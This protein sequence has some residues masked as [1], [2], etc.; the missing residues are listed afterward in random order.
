MIAKVSRRA[1][2]TTALCWLPVAAVVAA[3]FVAPTSQ[4]AAQRA[5]LDVTPGGNQYGGTNAHWEGNLNTSGE[6]RVWL[7]R[8][9]TPTSAWADVPDSLYVDTTNSAGHFSFD[10][11]T[12]A[13]NSVYFRVK[14]RT[15]ESPAHLFTSKHQEADLSLVELSPADVALPQGV[16]VGIAV[17]GEPIDMLV[18]TRGADKESRPILQGRAVTLQRRDITGG[19]VTWDFVANGTVG[20][21]G[22]LSFRFG[23]GGLP[24]ETGDYRVRLESW[25]QGGDQVGWYPSFPFDLKV[26]DRPGPVKNLNANA[27]SSSVKLT[28]DLPAGSVA[29]IVI[30]RSFS[31]TP[32]LPRDVIKD[33]LAGTATSYGD[34][35][36]FPST[37]YQY[38]V[39]TVSRD[40]VYT[41]VPDTT[42]VTT[43][44]PK[45]GER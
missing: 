33:D 30:A 3:L 16:A 28:W 7:Q 10:F 37:T 31:G 17:D 27:T 21:N 40:G 2:T 18:D 34:G 44:D 38:A 13:M 35:S 39:Y 4:G 29:R 20:N 12:P 1:L 41:R 32:S 42:T 45:R 36:V 23:P 43:P 26:V 8:R 6:Q 5:S 19:D 14:S 9:G 15:G 11:P 22:K 25:T 24:Q